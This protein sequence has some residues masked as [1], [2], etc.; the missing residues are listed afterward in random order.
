MDLRIIAFRR[1]IKD[2]G[3]GKNMNATIRRNGE[4][5]LFTKGL[6]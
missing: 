5:F 1:A 2:I 3:E 4:L 6:I